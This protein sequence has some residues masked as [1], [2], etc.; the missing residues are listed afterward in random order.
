[1]HLN[2]RTVIAKL[3][4]HYP[5]IKDWS[6]LENSIRQLVA[7]AAVATATSESMSTVHGVEVDVENGIG[8]LPTN[9]Y[10]FLLAKDENGNEIEAIQEANYIKP[11]RMVTG[12]VFITMRIVALDEDDMPIFDEQQYGYVF[13]YVFVSIMQEDYIIGKV[14]KYMWDEWI[15]KKDKAYNSA[16]RQRL[17]TQKMD[18]LVKAGKTSRY[19]TTNPKRY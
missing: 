1:M 8:L 16:I 9:C 10:K 5:N 2:Y 3:E 15:E 17:T 12:T 7:E 18:R 11:A 4:L 14:P 13:N 6:S 19:F